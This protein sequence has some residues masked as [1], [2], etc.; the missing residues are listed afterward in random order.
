[1]PPATERIPLEM[2]ELPQWVRWR[3]EPRRPGE[4]P[5]KIPFRPSGLS[6][7]KVDEPSTWGPYATAAAW[8]TVGDMA[9]VGFVFSD[10]GGLVGLD[11]DG[12][13]DPETGEIAEWA[14]GILYRFRGTYAEISPSRKGIKIVAHGR[15]PTDRTGKRVTLPGEHCGIE[16]YQRRRFFAVTGDL[17]PGH[18]ST[19]A[20][21]QA[22][23]DWLW[24][25][26][27]VP[28]RPEKQPQLVSQ[29]DYSVLAVDRRAILKRAAAYLEK[30]PP[31]IQGQNGSGATF[32]AACELFRFGLT[33]SEA[34]A[35]F[36]QYNG[37]CVPPWSVQETSHK[38]QDA[39]EEVEDTGEFGVRLLE[40]RRRQEQ[41][42]AANGQAIRPPTAVNEAEDDPHRLA[43]INMAQYASRRGGRTLRYW[44]D[45][46]YVWR[47]TNYRRITEKELRAKIAHACKQE[48]D[49]INVEKIER[50]EEKKRLGEIA[51]END[52]GPPV[53]KKV[54]Q[55]LVTNVLQATAGMTVLSSTIEPMTW[56]PTRDR[57]NYLA[58]QNGIIDMDAVIKD[59]DDYR[60]PHSPEW[61][62]TT[63]L[64]YQFNPDATCPRWE[65]FLEHNLELDPERIKMLQEWAGYLLLP[66][67]GQQKFLVLE[68]EGANGKSV[69][70]AAIEAMLGA[71]N[72]SHVPLEM[73]G[74]KFE[75]TT[76]LDKLV[77]ICG[78]AGELDKVA[79]GHL[80]AF[81][82]GNPMSFGR[83]YLDSVER[84]PTARLMMA[85]NN[86]PRFSDRSDGVWRRMLLVPWRIQIPA[87]DR[88]ANM[89]KPW[90]WEQSGELPGILLW[91]IM[92]LHRLRQQGRFTE[93]K[94]C[95]EALDDYR[96]EMNPARTFL[97][98]HL[99]KSETSK[100]K[101]SF[102]YGMYSRWCKASGHHPLSERQ[103]G[104]EI[105][106]VFRR[107]KKI[108]G[109]NSRERSYLYTGIC[110]SCDEICGEKTDDGI[111]F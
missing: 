48:F 86:R 30:L 61:F 62:S 22:A 39:R 11:L 63:C 19:V 98:E 26:W 29:A 97:Q 74:E 41:R 103:F 95:S 81:T 70:C 34:A 65:A 109:G 58:M 55:S 10:T 25:T 51:P 77:N 90:W 69:F 33:D 40:D 2:R 13:R 68:G 106:R 42:A 53:A 36:A 110:F 91:A 71:A 52:Q 21:C 67:T 24:Q 32:H 31:G 96:S 59:R 9:G 28:N 78:D 57:R 60:L 47:D 5:T 88:I 102:L 1:M 4:Q 101:S 93:S 43:R 64:P 75:L 105:F 107:C 12:C 99:E 8:L 85:V 84:I 83:K 35:L 46:W 87:S 82:A 15:L 73:F 66:D 17:V 76:T 3:V 38:L 14:T 37:R 111:F 89:D 49:R 108:R 23:L 45:E 100:I 16:A 27:I 80:K 94:I 7:A 50:Y 104:R 6:R 79:E 72:V 18:P 92:G 56:L 44:R 20:D 54:T